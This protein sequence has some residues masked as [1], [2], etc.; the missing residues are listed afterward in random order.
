M[1]SPLIEF[2]GGALD[3]LRREE[4]RSTD[5]HD[6][7]VRAVQNEGRHVEFLEIFGQV[8][9]GE[10]LNA[11]KDGFVSR[12]HP[13]QPKEL[14]QSLRHFCTRPVGSVERRT[15]ILEELRAVIENICAKFVKYFD[16]KAAGIARSF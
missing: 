10:S 3:D 11:V 8:R 15:E 7:I 16:R 13:L 2:Q 9:F 1:R 12:H 4:C 6:L 14:A 5:R